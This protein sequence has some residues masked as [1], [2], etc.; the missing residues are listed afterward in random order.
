MVDEVIP[1][2]E[3][4]VLDERDSARAWTVAVAAAVAGS[5]TFGTA[6]T[7]GTFFDSM[8][9]EFGAGRGSTAL[10]F[11][12]TLLLFFGTGV[13]SGPVSDRIGPRWL[14]AS[15]GALL[16]AGL[17]ATSRVEELWLGYLTYGIGVGLGSGLFVTPLY[18]TAGRW[19]VRRRAL[20]LGV[21]SAGNG[22]GTLTL[23]PLSERIVST[24]GWRT[25]YVWLAV[26]DAVL[27]VGVVAVV[28]RPRIAGSADGPPVSEPGFSVRAAELRVEAAFRTLVLVTVLGNISIFTAFAFIVPFAEDE[29]FTSSRAAALVAVVG[30]SSV[31]GRLAI[32][33]L[34]TRL[35]SVRLFQVSLAVQPVAYLVWLAGGTRYPMLIAFAVL[36]GVSYGGFVSL[37][38][39]VTVH[40]LS[41]VGL[42]TTF[43]LLFLAAGLGGLIGPPTVGVLSDLSGGRALPIGMVVAASVATFAA[44]LGLPEHPHRRVPADF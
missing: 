31:L 25:A 24:D 14:V 29:G 32:G 1:A 7:F 9:E 16:V 41:A 27:L 2:A 4:S 21:V 44:S 19:F 3:S 17:L 39:E 37:T 36:L 26:I 12:I 13:V 42:G 18:A 6:Y 20:A 34:A 11:S 22:I 33:A 43:G 30:A 23:V 15:G 35:S 8:A 40:L 10:V 28:R 38:P 5:V